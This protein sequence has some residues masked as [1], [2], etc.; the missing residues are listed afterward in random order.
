MSAKSCTRCGGTLCRTWWRGESYLSCLAC[1]HEPSRATEDPAYA[2]EL[3]R[4]REEK[5]REPGIPQQQRRTLP[6]HQERAITAL[7][8]GVR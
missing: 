1:G 6:E 2:A 8:E 3:R 5:P 4:E 7:Y